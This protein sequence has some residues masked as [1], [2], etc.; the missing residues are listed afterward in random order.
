MRYDNYADYQYFKS[1]TGNNHLIP[2]NEEVLNM[3]QNISLYDHVF[4][5]GSLVNLYG[6]RGD[7][8]IFRPTDTHIGNSACEAILV[9]ELIIK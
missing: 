4:I 7:Q 5:E 8:T 3:M 6:E 2:H 9:D 1:H